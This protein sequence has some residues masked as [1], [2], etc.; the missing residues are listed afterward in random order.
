[1]GQG[2]VGWSAP[3]VKEQAGHNYVLSDGR[4]DEMGRPDYVDKAGEVREEE[5]F[6]DAIKIEHQVSSSG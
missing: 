4:W 1:M 5:I 2:I 6:S 3:W